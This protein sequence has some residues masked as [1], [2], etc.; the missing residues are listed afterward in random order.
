MKYRIIATILL[1]LLMLPAQVVAEPQ[2]TPQSVITIT[3]QRQYQLAESLFLETEYATALAEFKRF[4]FFFPADARAP[5]AA[6]RIGQCHERLGNTDKALS[7]LNATVETYPGTPSALAAY[8]MISDVHQR[9]G[10]PE[11]ALINMQ[12]MIL[13]Y[14][15]P[16]IR[17]RIRYRMAWIHIET[18]QWAKAEKTLGLIGPVGLE[19]LPVM[20]LTADLK[21]AESIQYKNPSL[22][23]ALSII[24][25]GGQLYCGRHRDAL[26]ALLLNGGLIW[27]AVEAFDK[28]LYALGAVISV[29]EF[30]FY[31]GNI[32]GAVG[33]AHKYNDLQKTDFIENLKLKFTAGTDPFTESRNTA[34]TLGLSLNYR[35]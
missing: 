24:P 20:A 1:T 32:Y 9:S 16:G 11:Q 7:A 10:Q 29:V 21:R 27:A 35:F 6:L 3:A 26:V 23:G 2:D 28:E 5:G 4:L 25:G 30:G 31:A 22:A 8:F 34:P 12:N 18:G 13:L 19:D 14:P 17:D 33:S 15:A